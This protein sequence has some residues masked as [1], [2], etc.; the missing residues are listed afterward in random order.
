MS[1]SRTAGEQ[2]RW[3]LYGVSTRS[4]LGERIST[5]SKIEPPLDRDES[6]VV[7]PVSEHEAAMRPLERS[8]AN[9]REAADAAM[10]VL[11]AGSPTRSIQAEEILRA[12]L[13]PATTECDC[14]YCQV[15]GFSHDEPANAKHLDPE[16]QLSKP[17]HIEGTTTMTTYVGL[18]QRG[19]ILQQ[20]AVAEGGDHATVEKIARTRAA[21]LNAGQEPDGFELAWKAATLPVKT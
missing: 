4:Y 17:T 19:E 11:A 2:R 16:S 6:I 21:E 7:M 18:V 10:R 20:H 13:A 15:A 5:F 1:S 9:Q 12:A 3:T 14:D 8:I